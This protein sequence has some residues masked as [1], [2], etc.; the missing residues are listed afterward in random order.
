MMTK[1]ITSKV[2]PRNFNPIKLT[3]SSKM[4]RCDVLLITLTGY[5]SSNYEAA[6]QYNNNSVRRTRKSLK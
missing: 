5:K 6:I 2:I 1:H 3:I 4:T